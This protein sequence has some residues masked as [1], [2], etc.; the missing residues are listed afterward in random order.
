MLMAVSHTHTR[1]VY[2]Y[3]F[4]QVGR[5]RISPGLE[6]LLAPALLPRGSLNQQLLLAL[7]EVSRRGGHSGKEGRDTGGRSG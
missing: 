3:A 7:R 6:A 1:C 4:V 5:L 2:M